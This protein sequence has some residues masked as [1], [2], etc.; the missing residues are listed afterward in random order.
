M[1]SN[2][3]E[4]QEYELLSALNAEEESA[5]EYTHGK[6]AQDRENAMSEYLRE[7][8]GNEEEGRSGVI[9][10]DVMDAVEGM[11]PDIL[12]V[13]VSSDKAVQ[14]D[15]QS[16]EDAEGSEQATT[17]CNYVFYRQNNGFL[18]LYTA[19]KD[20]LLM[21]TGGVKWGWE[22]KRT[23][24]FTTYKGVTEAQIAQYLAENEDAE[25]LEKEER[26]EET[27]DE[28][29]QPIQQIVY[30]CKVRIVKTK[31]K[32]VLHNIPPEELLV[33]RNHSS[34]LLDN[35]PYVAHVCRKTLSDMQEMGFNV[36]VEDL[37][38]SMSDYDD[39]SENLRN[40]SYDDDELDHRGD[41]E[42]QEGWLKEE[43]IL[44]D[45]DGDG[46]AE[47][48]RVY[49]LNDTIL[50]VQEV[51]H[52]PLAAWTPTILTHQFYGLSIHDFV[53][54]IQ[55]MKSEIWRQ[56]M[57]NLSYTNNQRTA[58]LTDQNGN[59]KANIDDLLNPRPGGIVRE[60]VAGAARPMD[61]QWLGGQTIPMFEFL[62]QNKENRTGFTRYSQGLDSDALNQTARGVSLIMNASQKRMK[63]MSRILAECLVAP[64]FRGIFKTLSDYSM[65]EIS[66]KLSNK[67]VKYNP[68]E[69]RDGYDMVINVGLGTGDKEQNMLAFQQI[70]MAQEKLLA[71]GKNNLVSDKNIYN[72]TSRMSEN[73]GFKDVGEFFTDPEDKEAQPQIPP[74]VQQQ[75]QQMQE[76]LKQGG[77]EL[78]KT[79][80]ENDKLK[81]ENEV[82][83]TDVNQL[84]AEKSVDARIH[85]LEKVM[86]QASGELSNSN[87]EVDIEGNVLDRDKKRKVM[88]MQAPSGK[89]YE[90]VVE[91][92]VIQVATSDGEQLTGSIQ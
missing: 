3:N 89:V 46:I 63:L 68:Q 39:E 40:D 69:W 42:M 62:D 58:V 72:L 49:R 91:N 11:I 15:P 90:A 4:D 26:E 2:I 35:C 56:T 52:V 43:Y 54:D 59:P 41:D 13:F 79:K 64:M 25:I 22:E 57:D 53:T 28:Q 19:I 12:D 92:G 34:I 60:S 32:V 37:K 78:Q 77:E 20:A 86:L 50:E 81:S 23:P 33:S 44:F 31:G 10:S 76:A 70:A 85:Q 87:L 75:I 73:S 83:K 67:F 16:E 36:D 84:Q 17:A 80:E 7:P 27:Q 88:R 38:A 24:D 71:G 51:S 29:G 21:K 65:D 6:L 8:Y 5:A 9:S 14:F 74:Q 1:K 48:L 45:L 61:H 18:I 55:K 66:F 30:D 82:K 47:R